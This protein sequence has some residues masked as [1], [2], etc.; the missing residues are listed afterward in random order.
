MKWH[1]TLAWN[2]PLSYLVLTGLQFN[3]QKVSNQLFLP[4]SGLGTFVKSPIQD[5]VKL[6]MNVQ[7]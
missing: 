1:E 7:N 2:N 5:I 3:W 6:V 4:V